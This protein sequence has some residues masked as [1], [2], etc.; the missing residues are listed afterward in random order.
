MSV[1][2]LLAVTQAF[3]LTMSVAFLVY[4]VVI[5][6]PYLRRKPGPVGDPDGFTWHFFVPCRDEQTVIR[7]TIR[8]LRTTFRKAHVWV[9]DD[10]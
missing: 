1:K 9:V 5:V 8:Y 3:A 6:V 10:D 7:D 4:V 2:V